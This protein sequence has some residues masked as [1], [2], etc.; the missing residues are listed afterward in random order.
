MMLF[1]EKVQGRGRSKSPSIFLKRFIVKET[2]QN[3]A[4]D[5]SRK[6]IAGELLRIL[7]TGNLPLAFQG[8]RWAQCLV[9]L[10]R[11]RA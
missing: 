10:A 3:S 11:Y 4:Q 1:F 6:A 9:A 8:T 7:I 5:F 2:V